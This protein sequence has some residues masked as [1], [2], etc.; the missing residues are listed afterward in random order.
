MNDRPGPGGGLWSVVAP[1]ILVAGLLAVLL[2]VWLR[3]SFGT[4]PETR[5][6]ED[7]PPFRTLVGP[8]NPA[9]SATGPLTGIEGE[10]SLDEI[11]ISLRRAPCPILFGDGPAEAV[12]VA[13][14]TEHRCPHCRA[15]EADLDALAARRDLSFRITYHDL[16]IFGQSSVTAARAALAA[17][18]QGADVAMRQRLLRSGLV[19]DRAYVATVAQ[20]LGLDPDRLL[21]DMDRPEVTRRLERTREVAAA[22][23]IG[24]TP[25]LVIGRTVAFGRLPPD[26]I[27]RII[28]AEAAAPPLCD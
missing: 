20:S 24:G 7:L 3:G 10:A 8:T 1:M 5:P 26:H 9:I 4:G 22:L 14:F 28:R 18:R 25:G 15:L 6:L 23:G 12:P 21:A 2:A 27:A 16:P 13:V 19:V 17:E 11:R